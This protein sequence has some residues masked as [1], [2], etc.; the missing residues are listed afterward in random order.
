MNRTFVIA[1]GFSQF[2][3]WCRENKVSPDSPLVCYIA[4]GEADKLRGIR[5]PTVVYYGTYYER[6]DFFDIKEFVQ[7]RTHHTTG[8]L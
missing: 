8:R 1:N 5:N 2:R 7:L 6:K 4:D 3:S